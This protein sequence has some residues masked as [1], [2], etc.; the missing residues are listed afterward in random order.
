MNVGAALGI[1]GIFIAVLSFFKQARSNERTE[2]R[3][4]GMCFSILGFASS[5]LISV[6]SSGG[7]N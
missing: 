6:W 5:I 4:Y 2:N 1:L 3:L 7:V